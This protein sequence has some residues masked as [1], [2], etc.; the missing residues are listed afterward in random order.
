MKIVKK[1][2]KKYGVKLWN[3]LFSQA[4][5]ACAWAEISLGH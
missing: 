5:N 4:E 3:K 2:T 1:E